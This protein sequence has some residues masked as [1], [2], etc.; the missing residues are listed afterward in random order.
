MDGTLTQE[1]SSWETLFRIYHHDPGPFYRM[2]AEGKIDQDGW[3]AGNLREII[4][5]RP[6][7]TA[8]EVED[9]L[10]DHTHLRDGVE[11]CISELTSLGVRC[12]IISAGA[13]PLARW[14]GARARFHDWRANW[15]E[16]DA[17]GRLV[18]NYIRNVSFMEKERWLR[19]WM[20]ALGISR[21]E[22]VAVGD[23]C[24]DV[25]MFREAGHS[26][27]FNPTDERAATMGEVVHRGNDL[28]DC[29]RTI[30]GWMER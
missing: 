16:T 12:V 11:D 18:P 2:Y 8:R 6:G 10:I 30:K 26:I 27:A 15:F 3:A 28:G 19:Y 24:N 5:G 13:E 1:T 21:E 7:L 29:M 23:S 14:I 22:V 20:S 4:R 25:G 17:E 9:A